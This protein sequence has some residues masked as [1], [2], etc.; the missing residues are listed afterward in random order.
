MR[1]S[2][3]AVAA[4]I[5]KTLGAAPE[6]GCVMTLQGLSGTGKGTTVEKLKLSLPKAV[7][8]SNGN[9]SRSNPNPNP[10]R[11]LKPNLNPNP[12]RNP[13]P[14]PDPNPNPTPTP[15]QSQP[16]PQPGNVFRAITLLAI[17]YCEQ[18]K[19]EFSSEALTAEVLKLCVDCLSFG[20]FGGKFDIKICGLGLDLLVSQESGKY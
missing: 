10:N 1:R 4:E 6:Q 19:L 13:S 2:A 3:D 15:T 16:Q 7:T 8:W 5:V 14:D 9:V 11:N 18:K 20:K 12:N 17:T